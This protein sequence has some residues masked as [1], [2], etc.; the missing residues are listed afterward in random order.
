[1]TITRHKV[2]VLVL[3]ALMTAGAVFAGSSVSNTPV[4]DAHAAKAAPAEA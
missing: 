3:A 1:M 2:A 4:N